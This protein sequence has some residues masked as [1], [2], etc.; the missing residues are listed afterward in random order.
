MN[1]RTTHKEDDALPLDISL[2]PR[3][4]VPNDHTVGLIVEPEI[5]RLPIAP[6]DYNE[7]R[8]AVDARAKTAMWRGAPPGVK[9]KWENLQPVYLR[10]HLTDLITQLTPDR[11]EDLWVFDRDDW[12]GSTY[13]TDIDIGDD[14]SETWKKRGNKIRKMLL[15]DHLP[16]CFWKAGVILQISSSGK[17]H[18][19]FWFDRP[20]LSRE[21]RGWIGSEGRR[22]DW[23]N[24]LLPHQPIYTAR[25][26]TVVRRGNRLD[27][28][29]D[30]VRPRLI[31]FD[32]PPV[33]V[34]DELP[35]APMSGRDGVSYGEGS[36]IAPGLEFDDIVQMIGTPYQ[37]SLMHMAT[38]HAIWRY[39]FEN[40]HRDGGPDMEECRGIIQRR[41]NEVEWPPAYAARAEKLEDFDRHWKKAYARLKACPPMPDAHGHSPV[42]ER[43]VAKESL[44]ERMAMNPFWRAQGQVL[45]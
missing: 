43:V 34:P 28:V 3:G 10:A 11:E 17:F 36:G 26:R 9:R 13:V 6:L 39:Q 12:F 25:P 31:L 40:W 22:V 42:F 4:R 44:E 23:Q 5:D 37:G 38:V 1:D 2:A 21:F 27:T 16:E 45:K 35:S 20:I 32:G 33:P 15:R 8:L 19:W 29:A 14:W 24:P 41:F 30:P 18:L 7:G